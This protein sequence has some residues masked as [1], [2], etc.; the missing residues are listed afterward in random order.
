[1][2]HHQNLRVYLP[3]GEHLP[4]GARRSAEGNGAVTVNVTFREVLD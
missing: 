1:M 4:R 3:M 2:C